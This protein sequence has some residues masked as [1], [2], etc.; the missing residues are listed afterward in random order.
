VTI[1]GDTNQTYSEFLK[2]GG[3]IPYNKRQDVVD[4][5][6]LND[7]KEFAAE[8][9]S[10]NTHIKCSDGDFV[11]ISIGHGTGWGGIGIRRSKA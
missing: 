9:A 4:S 7:V 3:A 11:S 5:K 8:V 10:K 1:H 2:I 6:F